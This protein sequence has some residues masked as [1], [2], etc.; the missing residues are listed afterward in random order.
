[1]D[2]RDLLAQTGVFVAMQQP[3]SFQPEVEGALAAVIA[4]I[5]AFLAFF[6]IAG[7]LINAV[8]CFLLSKCYHSIPEPYRLMPPIQV[9]LLMIPCFPLVWNFFV[10]L[11]LADSY[12]SYFNA[13]GRYDVGDCGKAIGLAYCICVCCTLLPYAGF[14]SAI[15]ALVL[16]IM[17]LI[18]AFQLKAMISDSPQG[19][20]Y[21]TAQ[22][23]P[24][25]YAPGFTPG[26][27]QA[28]PG[29]TPPYPNSGPFQ[30]PK[31]L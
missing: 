8:V 17:F 18:K 19:F 12:K 25:G 3:P 4:I 29:P 2:H 28:S 11:K 10:Y 16:M 26:S 7:L 1:M 13:V 22:S 5:I 6:L 9:W 24:P 30:P 14:V 27:P 23:Y 31:S 21:G 15:A 20:A